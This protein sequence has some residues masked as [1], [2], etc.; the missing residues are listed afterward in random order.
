[1]PA[2]GLQGRTEVGRRRKRDEERWEREER[3]NEVRTEVQH[4]EE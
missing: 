1:M 3:V 2:S 4:Y